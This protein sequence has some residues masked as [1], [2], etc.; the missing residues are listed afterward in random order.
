VL[1]EGKG[2]TFGTERSCALVGV[3]YGQLR[4]QRPTSHRM[5]LGVERNCPGAV[6]YG[7][8]RRQRPTSHRMTLGVE[9]D[10]LVAAVSIRF[11]LG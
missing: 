10:C 8:L 9:H 7:Q 4:S 2:G 11:G 1:G 3:E 6:E 5:T